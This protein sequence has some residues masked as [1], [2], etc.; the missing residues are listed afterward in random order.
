MDHL[1]IL[2]NNA[3]RIILDMPK[4][5]SASK[6]LEQLNWKPLSVRRCHHRCI[7]IF[8]CLNKL[9]DFDF[10]LIS[11]NTDVHSYNTRS[12]AMVLI[13]R[14]HELNWGKQRFITH[15]A[16]DWNSLELKVRQSTTLTAFKRSLNNGLVIQTN[17]ISDFVCLFLSLVCNFSLL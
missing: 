8:K 1:Q 3:A 16:M 11:R 5:F 12:I 13:F 7:A 17:L 6:A 4:Y 10:N 9:A 2:Q 14:V 15:A